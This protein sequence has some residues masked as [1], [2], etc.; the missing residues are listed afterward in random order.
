MVWN[1]LKCREEV[2][3]RR[4]CQGSSAPDFLHS[5]GTYGY[6][7]VYGQYLD[8]VNVDG[9]LVPATGEYPSIFDQFPLVCNVSVG[10]IGAGQGLRVVAY[11]GNHRSN[12]GV[13]RVDDESKAC[14]FPGLVPSHHF[15]F[16]ESAQ[17]KLS[18]RVKIYEHYR[19]LN[20][21]GKEQSK[22]FLQY[23]KKNGRICTNCTELQCYRW[24]S[25]KRPAFLGPGPNLCPQKIT[26]ATEYSSQVSQE[27]TDDCVSLSDYKWCKPVR[28]EN[29]TYE[30][31]PHA[32]L[33][34]V[35]GIRGIL[36]EGGLSWR[37]Y[38]LP[39]LTEDGQVTLD[40]FFHLA[41]DMKL[42]V[43]GQVAIQRALDMFQP[44]AFTIQANYSCGSSLN[45]YIE[46]HACCQSHLG[47]VVNKAFIEYYLIDQCF[48][49]VLAFQDSR[50]I[51]FRWV[52]RMRADLVFFGGATALREL[53]TTQVLAAG[54]KPK[55]PGASEMFFAVP[56]EADQCQ[57]VFQN[58]LPAYTVLCN[59]SAPM[60]QEVSNLTYSVKHF[61]E[62]FI[63]AEK[64]KTSIELLRTGVVIGPK[65]IDCSHL[66]FS[67][68]DYHDCNL[69]V[70]WIHW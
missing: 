44:V 60:G 5:V 69:A 43:S 41:L 70:K 20:R 11:Q 9:K 67:A 55:K 63:E 16:R 47:P 62:H 14:V 30:K 51:K 34:V 18:E 56:C 10:V 33:C 13:G 8:R 31:L 65:K 53:K 39:R 25:K 27:K 24:D 2:A 26:T 66:K 57:R 61:W 3:Q 37:K 42:D 49:S 68:R 58:I 64:L 45:N 29:T 17:A 32:A 19:T 22:K 36:R 46:N 15:K 21:G 28:R 48:T 4:S 54:K 59:N 7:A 50:K 52:V 12:S 35:G 23:V 40:T 38:L 6:D 1:F